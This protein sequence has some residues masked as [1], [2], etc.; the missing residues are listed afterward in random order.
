MSRP[1]NATVARAQRAKADRT[2]KSP[3]PR[4][5]KPRKPHK[6]TPESRIVLAAECWFDLPHGPPGKIDLDIGALLG[7]CEASMLAVLN[8]AVPA[9]TSES[10]ATPLEKFAKA[11][12]RFTA[13]RAR[14]EPTYATREVKDAEVMLQRL[15]EETQAAQKEKPAAEP[16][17]IVLP[18]G[19]S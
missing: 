13:S 15:V 17:L 3:K 5:A 12:I 2:R 18:G 14:L 10:T 11:G 4:T 7:L 19:S 6:C 16:S 8:R 9:V 1:S